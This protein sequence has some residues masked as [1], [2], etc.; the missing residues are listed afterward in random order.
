MHKFTTSLL[1]GSLSS[2]EL[3]CWAICWVPSWLLVDSLLVG[4]LVGLLH[5]CKAGHVVTKV[6]LWGSGWKESHRN[7]WSLCEFFILFSSRGTL[8]T[9]TRMDHGPLPSQTAPSPHIHSM[10]SFTKLI[11][12]PHQWW[13]TPSTNRATSPFQDHII[14]KSYFERS[15]VGSLLRSTGNRPRSWVQD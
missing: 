14:I 15:P 4:H 5:H 11:L 3:S 7:W 9:G 13:L 8:F 6:N 1:P 10:T 2:M 12:L